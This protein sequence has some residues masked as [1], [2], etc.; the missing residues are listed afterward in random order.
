MTEE[1]ILT[2]EMVKRGQHQELYTEWAK[3]GHLLA[4]VFL[5]I[6]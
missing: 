4:H 5:D 3:K 1:I 2:P 6:T